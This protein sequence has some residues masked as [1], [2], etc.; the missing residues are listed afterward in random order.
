MHLKMLLKVI[1]GLFFIVP[2]VLVLLLLHTIYFLDYSIQ[3][4]PELS[5]A[6]KPVNIHLMSYADGA[7]IYRQNQNILAMSAIHRGVDFIYN[8]RRNHI[9]SAFI[10]A[11]PIMSN[12]TGAGYWLW[13]SYLILETLKKIPEGDILIYA[14]TGLLIRQD[15]RDYFT[16][17]LGDKDVLLFAYNPQEYKLAATIASGDVFD[18]L[19]CRNDHCRYGHHV[20]A[21]ILVLRNSKQSRSFIEQWLRLGKN[22]DLLT[23][24]KQHSLPF[25]EFEFHQHD[26]GLLSVLAAKQAALVNFISMDR[27]FFI[28]INMHR[29]KSNRRSLLGCFS[30]QYSGIERRILNAPMTQIIQGYLAKILDK[31]KNIKVNPGY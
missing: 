2:V 25:P 20:W 31:S 26:E 27:A 5:E 8:Y 28:H 7:E 23:G 18:A 21:G 24:R 19:H 15:I 12:P 1:K 3:P 9:D 17:G 29:R 10:H 13:K 11:N 30:I 14:D 4:T 6:Q 16:K 22:T